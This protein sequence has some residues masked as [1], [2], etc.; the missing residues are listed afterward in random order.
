MRHLVLPLLLLALLVGCRSTPPAPAIATATPAMAAPEATA[1]TSA[2]DS[3]AL[4][5][6]S[7]TSVVSGS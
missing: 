1:A 6:A 4:P 2:P 3:P 5:V 7:E